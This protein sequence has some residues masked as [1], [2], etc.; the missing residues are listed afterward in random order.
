M[1]GIIEMLEQEIQVKQKFLHHKELLKGDKK[2]PVILLQ[3][4][5]ELKTAIKLL[6]QQHLKGERKR[7][8]FE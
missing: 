3:E 5:S 1:H 2:L 4:I 8:V 7:Q 6:K